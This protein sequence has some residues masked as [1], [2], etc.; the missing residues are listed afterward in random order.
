M[1]LIYC[2]ERVTKPG[3]LD[4]GVYNIIKE[5][6]IDELPEFIQYQ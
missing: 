2:A 4:Q 1:G 3:K 5:S 6:L